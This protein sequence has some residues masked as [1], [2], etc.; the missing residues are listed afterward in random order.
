MKFNLPKEI[1]MESGL[2]QR[3]RK[4]AIYGWALGHDDDGRGEYAYL[5]IIFF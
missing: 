5:S 3:L 1:P 2:T 4:I